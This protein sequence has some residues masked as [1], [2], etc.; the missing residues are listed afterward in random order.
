[1]GLGGPGGPD[2]PAKG[3]EA[4]PLFGKVFGATCPDP[5]NLGFAVFLWP[6]PISATPMCNRM[7]FAPLLV[8]MHC[9]RLPDF[10][11]FFGVAGHC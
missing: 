7:M 1:M 10:V 3:G 4:S 8:S 2:N 11:D 9:L 6:P 5:R